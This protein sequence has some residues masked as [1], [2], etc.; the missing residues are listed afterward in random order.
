MV[1]SL[2]LFNLPTAQPF[3]LHVDG[4][5]GLDFVEFYRAAEELAAGRTPYYTWRYNKPPT[6]A[7]AAIPLTALSLPHAKYVFFIAQLA[8]LIAACWLALTAFFA[9]ARGTRLE[10]FVLTV[11]LVTV[12]YPVHFLLDRGNLDGFVTLFVVAAAPLAMRVSGGS[13]LRG[14]AGGVLLACGVL[15]K[16]YPVVLAG[17][18][19]IARR[20]W[21]LLGV[22]ITCVVVV[23]ITHEVW[24]E[25]V[26]RIAW[27][28]FG[29]VS[30]PAPENASI[31]STV[32]FLMHPFATNGVPTRGAALASYAIY[33]SAFLACMVRDARDRARLD[34]RALL[35]RLYLYMPFLIAMP[36]LS[37]HYGLVL[38]LPLTFALV[39]ARL[40]A[41]TARA[42][43]VVDVMLV[44]ALLSQFPSPAFQQIWNVPAA[45]RIP[46]LGLLIVLLGALAYRSAGPDGR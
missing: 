32:E 8:A 35:L 19:V 10:L 43:R 33:A 29:Y 11:A 16:L 5:F 41:R 4:I 24:L 45:A 46:G 6:V 44:G 15:T 30:G 20:W 42:R 3:S 34:D 7:Y 39:W 31:A 23:A 18:L 27:G 37:F 9:P 14:M 17:P 13:A 12:S 28:R 25:F 36:K 40:A 2:L 26:Q 21:A 1:G 38:F 22:A